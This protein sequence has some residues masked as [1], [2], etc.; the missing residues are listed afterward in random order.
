[1]LD[2]LILVADR[3]I[4]AL[5]DHLGEPSGRAGIAKRTWSRPGRGPGGRSHFQPRRERGGSERYTA[6]A[7]AL[8]CD[9]K[10]NGR[11]G[12]Q[13]GLATVAAVRRRLRRRRSRRFASLL[14]RGPPSGRRHSCRNGRCRLACNAPSIRLYAAVYDQHPGVCIERDLLADGRNL[15]SAIPVLP[16]PRDKK[17]SDP[18]DGA[19]DVVFCSQ[20]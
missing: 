11:M 5:C 10:T 18:R 12:R 7:P 4:V 13:A 14:K 19:V 8:R 17:Q 6:L 9:A 3:P 2:A 20:V 16:F 15:Q 1:M